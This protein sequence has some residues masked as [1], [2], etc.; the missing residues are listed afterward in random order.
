[1]NRLGDLL[2]IC[3]GKN[4]DKTRP[5]NDLYYGVVLKEW[6]FLKSAS[7]AP[8]KE[9]LTLARAHFEVWLRQGIAAEKVHLHR[10]KELF[11][12][13]LDKRG[14]ASTIPVEIWV[15]YCRVLQY[16]GDN[17][18]ASTVIKTIITTFESDVDLPIY[19][20]FAGVIFKALGQREVAN[21]YFFEATQIGPPKFF[22]KMDMMMI[23][24]RVIEES[25]ADGNEDAYRIVYEH[26]ML[27]GHIA[28][29]L[30]YDDWLSDSKTWMNFADKC[31][32]YQQF[33]LA[34]DFYA[35]GI[36]KDPNAFKKPMLWYRFAKSCNRCG[37]ISDAELS[38]NVIFYNHFYYYYYHHSKLEHVRLITT[39]CCEQRNIGWRRK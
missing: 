34:T 37:R 9:L 7:T 22:S 23:I 1:M 16:L 21:N 11:A 13:F 19:M 29:D 33:S 36:L 35:L 32:I 25:D 38:I 30:D 8:R 39:S 14:H 31:A 18:T 24:S 6:V 15:E 12:E 4:E 20:F 3:P 26:L 27:E 2:L 17:Q 28:E 10:A 5:F